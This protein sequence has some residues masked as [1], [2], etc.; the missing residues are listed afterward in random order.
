[1]DELHDSELAAFQALLLDH[2]ERG[3]APESLK[4][5][6]L[7]DPAGAP[8]TAYIRSFDPRCLAIAGRIVQKWAV[9]EG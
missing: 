8:F 9:R 2:L 7:A 1:M 3:T 5:S 6:L 4:S